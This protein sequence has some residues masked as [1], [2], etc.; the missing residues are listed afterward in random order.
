[1]K[2]FT[3][4]ELCK[5]NVALKHNINNEPNELIKN[6]L[7]KLVNNCLD[8]IREEWGKP[9]Y[10]NSGYRCE[11][12]NRLVKG[13]ITSHHLFGLAADIT[14]KSI[15]DNKRLFDLI[16]KLKREGKIQFTQLIDESDYQWL[17][18]SY[19]DADLK[20]QVLHLK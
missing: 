8:I 14:T 19:W 1:M 9:I 16:L 15:L 5:S 11:E 2:Y 18:L 10:V 13:S 12:L 7:G 6:N 3:I 17:H 4:N 20:N